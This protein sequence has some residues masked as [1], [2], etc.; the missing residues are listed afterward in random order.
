MHAKETDKEWGVVWSVEPLP[1]NSEGDERFATHELKWMWQDPATGLNYGCCE[2]VHLDPRGLRL[3]G[4]TLYL[5]CWRS[6]AAI[7]KPETYAM[8]ECYAGMDFDEVVEKSLAAEET[9][10]QTVK[11]PQTPW[12]LG[13]C[14][15]P[16]N[17]WDP[18]YAQY[19]PPGHV[20]C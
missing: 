4:I 9:F 1:G 12:A 3:V 15:T 20:D 16:D 7:V 5:Q 18:A 6:L 13:V 8:S 11:P 10:W 17:P 2:H 14:P 19:M